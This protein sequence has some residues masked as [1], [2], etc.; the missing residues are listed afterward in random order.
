MTKCDMGRGG[1]KG[2]SRKKK[3]FNKWR[4]CC[5]NDL[6]FDMLVGKFWFILCGK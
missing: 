6:F 5:L 4:A 2:R 3:P 1:G